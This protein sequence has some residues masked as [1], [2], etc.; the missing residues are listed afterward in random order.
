MDEWIK[1]LYYISLKCSIIEP[2]KKKKPN[3]TTWDNLDDFEGIV[4]S[5]ISWKEKGNY[6]MILFCN[7]KQNTNKTNPTEKKKKSNLWLPEAGDRETVL[8][9]GGQKVQTS[10]L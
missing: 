7:L 4:I 5:E 2:W 8:E 1:K 3:S 9:E 6:C 10:Q